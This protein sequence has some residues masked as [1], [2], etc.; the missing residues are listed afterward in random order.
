MTVTKPTIGVGFL[1][2]GDISVLHAAAVR[3]CPGAELVG[4]W[5]RG[6]DRAAQ[7]AA[8]FG[9]RTYASPAALVNDPAVDAVF[10]LTNLETHLEYTELALTAG[11][12]GLVEKPVRGTVGE[13]ERMAR[14]AEEKG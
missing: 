11:K 6:R 2:A 8:A 5:N 10:V 7:R 12:H 3:K 1:G 4:L 14:R 13:I 9:C